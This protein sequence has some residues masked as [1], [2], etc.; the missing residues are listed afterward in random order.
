M[1]SKITETIKFYKDFTIEYYTHYPEQFYLN[2]VL[3]FTIGFVGWVYNIPIIVNTLRLAFA[4]NVILFG[5]LLSTLIVGTLIYDPNPNS[6]ESD[7][8]GYESEVD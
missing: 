5:L 4:I 8:E 1:N 7:D 6:K 2:T 3:P